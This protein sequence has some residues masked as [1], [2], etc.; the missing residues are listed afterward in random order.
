MDVHA[1]VTING[2]TY[3]LT[4]ISQGAGHVSFEYLSAVEWNRRY[5]HWTERL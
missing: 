5:T 3:I 4:N 1:E 2:E